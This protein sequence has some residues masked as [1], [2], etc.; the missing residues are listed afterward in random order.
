MRQN[1]KFSIVCV[2]VY[3][4]LYTVSP[5]M[6]IPSWVIGT[7]YLLSPF[8]VVWMVISILKGEAYSGKTF[9]EGY[10]YADR[11]APKSID[12]DK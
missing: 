11:N 9:D 1:Y 8:L 4:I 3:L 10:F 2:T 6:D 12:A 5:Y 7:A